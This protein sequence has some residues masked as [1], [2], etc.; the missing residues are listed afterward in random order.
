MEDIFFCISKNKQPMC[1]GLS[2]FSE[3][4]KFFYFT[5]N[6]YEDKDV[7]IQRYGD[8]YKNEFSDKDDYEGIKKSYRK[9]GEDCFNNLEGDFAII[10]CDKKKLKLLA[11][12][13]SFGVKSLYYY[14]D[15]SITA[16]SNNALSFFKYL[17]INKEAN[18][19]K[20]FLYV[21]SHYRYFDA[22]RNETF[23]SNIFAVKQGCFISVD[24]QK[25]TEK[26]F[27]DLTLLDLG[28]ADREEIKN[29]YV[30]LLSQSIESRLSKSKNPAFMISSGMD[31]S[32]VVA[33]ASGILGQKVNI[34]TTVFEEDVE[35]NEANEIKP[36]AKKFGKKWNKLI[37]KPN[38]LKNDLENILSL[39]SEPFATIT[40]ML[41]YY[42][43]AE[44]KAQGFDSI[45]GGLGGD[46]ANCGE[47][48][49]YLFFFADLRLKNEEPRLKEEIK[50]WV[51]NHAH[52]LYP[53]SYE[54]ADNFLSKYIDFKSP[55]VNRLDDDRFGRYVNIFNND[56][57]DK[58]FNRPV[59]VHP[60]GSYLMN[61]LYQDLYFETI[62]CVLRAEEFNLGNF[63][64]KGRMPYLDR[65]VMQYGFSIPVELKYKGGAN[66]AILREAM[67]GILPKKTTH[68][69]VKKGW[70][71]PFNK[72]LK[73]SLK[74]SID[75]ILNKPT[76]R[77][78]EIYNLVLIKKLFH[79][80]VNDKANHM[81]FFWQ[82]L[83]YEK[84]YRIHF[85]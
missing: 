73:T 48:E 67:Q 70:N 49:E 46:E 43:T 3:K 7:I 79:E 28:K 68:N 20:H 59:L 2:S 6:C 52:I 40:Q 56:F 13:D 57:R 11:G 14:Q 31:S 54:I 84:W 80:H 58:N 78:M 5:G 24:D 36:V 83:N 29:K 45:F 32:S 18:P 63:N 74:D 41:H 35:Y 50:G 51:K 17:P 12:R 33:L 53:K 9:Y 55:G 65:H 15:D 42:L 66:K 30:A 77:Q 19:K 75:A 62:P 38:N 21:G 64:L 27:W 37:V 4:D 61:K 82:F 26:C 81:M 1:K 8:I 69:F 44:V 25:M 60:Y 76:V 72:W 23:F 39:S 22:S 16:F 71:A 85:G 47:I 34:F 10:I